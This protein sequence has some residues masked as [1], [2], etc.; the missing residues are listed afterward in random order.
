[1]HGIL[2]LPSCAVHDVVLLLAGNH[3]NNKNAFFALLLM[4]PSSMLM[5][6]F[7]SPGL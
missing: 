6:L 1:M 2:N 3:D 7:S 5:G 4:D